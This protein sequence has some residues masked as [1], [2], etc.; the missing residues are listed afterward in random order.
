M[1]L[2]C[3]I[4]CDK[5]A[6]SRQI[7]NTKNPEKLKVLILKMINIGKKISAYQKRQTRLIGNKKSKKKT[8]SVSFLKN[9]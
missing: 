1:T 9:E 5:K 3:W 8:A 6:P 4:T 7:E 2:F